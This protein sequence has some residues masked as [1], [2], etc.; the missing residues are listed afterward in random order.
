MTEEVLWVMRRENKII[1]WP[2]YFDSTKS[3][4]EGR[5]APK[6]LAIPSPRLSEVKEAVEALEIKYE[7]FEDVAHPKTSRLK[8][9]LLVVEKE[10]PKNQIIRKI[11]KQLPRIRSSSAPR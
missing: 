4:N 6:R 3:R 5:R 10:E 11:G 7:Y 2:V 1:I 9:G 8:T